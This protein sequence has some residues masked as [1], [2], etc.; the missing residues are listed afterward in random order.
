MKNFNEF[1]E[2]EV[3]ALAITLEEEDGRIYGDFADGLQ[4]HYPATAKVFR[5][6]GDRGGRT[7]P[8]AYRA[9]P[10]P[11]FGEHIPLIRR[12]D[13]KGFVRRR[14][15]WLIKHLS[16]DTCASRPLPWR[17][18]DPALLRNPPPKRSID[19]AIRQL[20]VDLAEAERDHDTPPRALARGA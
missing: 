12:E 6:H 10:Q 3:L 19:A 20:L 16:L 1:S 4:E 8:P 2:R 15:V 5:S 14:P 9:L 17:A 11:S 13:V 18:G 7:S